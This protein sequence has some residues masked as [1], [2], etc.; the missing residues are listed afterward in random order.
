MACHG[1]PQGFDPVDFARHVRNDVVWFAR[2]VGNYERWFEKDAAF[3][4]NTIVAYLDSA[5]IHGRALAEFC[6]HVPPPRKYPDIRA[7]HYL[8][9]TFPCAGTS[10][11][12]LDRWKED[13]D[14]YLAHLTMNRD[15]RPYHPAI[16]SQLTRGAS[17]LNRWN[18]LD[19][20]SLLRPVLE[21]VAQHAQVAA[22]Q[23]AFRDLLREASDVLQHCRTWSP[24]K[25]DCATP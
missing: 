24:P 10:D 17:Y 5:L 16:V 1:P 9:G 22:A 6:R 20:W 7:C 23:A 12:M 4:P 18:L 11:P 19:L 15:G 8:L 21:N 2:A 25:G 3:P 13:A 14:T